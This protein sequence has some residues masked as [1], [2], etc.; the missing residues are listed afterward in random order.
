MKQ[1]IYELDIS[2]E[3]NL[4]TVTPKGPY[5]R[6]DILNLILIVVRDPLYKPIYNSIIDLRFI[7][8][9]LVISDV[10]AISEF[11]LSVKKCFRRK[12]ALVVHGEPL[13][14]MFKLSAMF[15]SRQGLNTNIFHDPKEALAWIVEP[16]TPKV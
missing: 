16:D 10:F 15:V 4:V 1:M 13:Y 7:K 8:Y 2:D 12:T 6:K 3:N 11:I 9:D 5:S 14:N